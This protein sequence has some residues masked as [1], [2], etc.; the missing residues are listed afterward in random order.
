MN[1]K[2]FLT[3]GDWTTRVCVGNGDGD[4]DGNG[5]GNVGVADLDGGPEG[6]DFDHS[7]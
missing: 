7:L 2:Y 1:L 4:G 5:N 6:T 3:V